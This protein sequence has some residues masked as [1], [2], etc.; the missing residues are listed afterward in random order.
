MFDRTL[1]H[2]HQERM[3]SL[4]AS[5]VYVFKANQGTS[6]PTIEGYREHA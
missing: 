1:S 5:G 2:Q 6:T 3:R 4:D